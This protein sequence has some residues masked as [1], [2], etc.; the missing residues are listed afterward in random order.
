MLPP[1][2]QRA[3]YE[4]SSPGGYRR[5]IRPQWFY[6]PV[7]ALAAALLHATALPAAAAHATAVGAKSLGGR[8]LT[9]PARAWADSQW[10]RSLG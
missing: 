8:P 2:Q 4:R 7:P 10:R 6:A 9:S 3:T 5:A 1:H